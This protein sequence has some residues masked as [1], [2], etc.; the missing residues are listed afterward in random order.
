MTH[1]PPNGL[2]VFFYIRPYL[3]LLPRRCWCV[4]AGRIQT[5]CLLTILCSPAMHVA[6]TYDNSTVGQQQLHQEH[7]PRIWQR[8]PAGWICSAGSSGSASSL[9]STRC[10][11]AL[12]RYAVARPVEQQI[13][14]RRVGFDHNNYRSIA[15]GCWLITSARVYCQCGCPTYRHIHEEMAPDFFRKFTGKIRP[16]AQTIL[17]RFQWQFQFRRVGLSACLIVGELVCRPVVQLPS[18]GYDIIWSTPSRLM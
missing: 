18:V 16:C 12:S 7:R 6:L 14:D 3:S 9:H 13:I 15:N 10:I 4:R 17:Y 1:G 8:K 11:R 2:L 5:G